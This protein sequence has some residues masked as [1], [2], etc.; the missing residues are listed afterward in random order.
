MTNNST[1]F[2]QE[3]TVFTGI[4]PFS[5]Y[6]INAFQPYWQSQQVLMQFKEVVLHEA[7]LNTAFVLD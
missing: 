7:A 4:S 2:T 6:R 3:F 5:S 1:I